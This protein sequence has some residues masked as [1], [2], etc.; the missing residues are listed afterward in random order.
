M[1]IEYHLFVAEKLEPLLEFS[2]EHKIVTAAFSSLWPILPTT[3]IDARSVAPED[4]R[5][6]TSKAATS[7]ASARGSGVTS[8]QI[9]MKWTLMKGVVVV[10]TSSKPSRIE[11]YVRTDDMPDLIG[12]EMEVLKNAVGGTHL[13]AY[14]SGKRMEF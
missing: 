7:L 13:R 12:E 8:N 4:I 2:R 11:E 1:Q 3:T 6:R 14:V 9:I 5:D 10:T